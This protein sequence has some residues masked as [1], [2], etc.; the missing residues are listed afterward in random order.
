MTVDFNLEIV[1]TNFIKWLR[2]GF[3]TTRGEVFDV[4]ITTSHA[5]YRLERGVPPDL[6]GGM[7]ESENG[8]G[9]LMR[10]LPLV[11]CIIDKPLDERFQ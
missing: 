11:A 4:G 7:D 3:W 9:S 6:A 2:E 1:A 10:I 8:N 5:I